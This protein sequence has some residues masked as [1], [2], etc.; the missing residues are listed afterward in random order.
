MVILTASGCHY[1][2]F[3]SHQTDSSYFIRISTKFY[4]LLKRHTC[5]LYILKIKTIADVTFSIKLKTKYENVYYLYNCVLFKELYY[6]VVE[7]LIPF[8]VHR[9]LNKYS[10]H[11]PLNL[12]I[13]L[14]ASTGIYCQWYS[15]GCEEIASK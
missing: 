11:L 6:S 15:K 7:F 13:W 5:D 1:L 12:K 2:W 8:K 10:F 4:K 9:L 3:I 14:R